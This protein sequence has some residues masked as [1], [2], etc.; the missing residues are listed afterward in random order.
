MV[1]LQRWHGWCHM[2][3]LLSQR[4]FCV[5]HTTMPLYQSHIRKAYVCLTVTCHLHFWQNDWDLLHA[6]VTFTV[7]C[8]F[9]SVQ[10]E[11]KF[12]NAYV[13]HNF[14]NTE[15]EHNFTNTEFDFTNIEVK[16]H[17]SDTEVEYNF[18]NTDA[19]FINTE[20]KFS[21]TLMQIS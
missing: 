11:H 8:H 9:T 14:P 3:L 4:K 20:V 6:T 1:Y 19:N 12:I 16:Y 2:T 7:E 13:E 18:T 5:H 10:A 15:V 17:F 21:P